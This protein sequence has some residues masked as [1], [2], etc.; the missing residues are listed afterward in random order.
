[1]FW[2]TLHFIDIVLWLL[3]TASTFYVLLFALIFL[4]H[5]RSKQLPQTCEAKRQHRFLVLFPAYGEDQIIVKSVASFLQQ[6]Y[7]ESHYRIMVIS[8]HMTAATNEALKSLPI[9]LL[10]PAFEHSSKAKALQFAIEEAERE[11]AQSESAEARY[12]YVVILD[13]DNIVCDDFLSYLN[14]SCDRGYR[15]IQCHRCAKNADNNIAVLDGLSEEINNSIFRKAHNLVGLSSAL[16]GSGMCIDYQWFASHVGQLSTA[17]EDR[18]LEQLLLL[19]RIFIRY[20][21]HIPVFDEKVGSEDN[22]QRQR[23]RWMSAQLNSLVTML[24]HVGKAL[25]TGNIN[26][27]DK[28]IQQALIPRSM[29]LV[30]TLTM[31]VVMVLFAPWWSMKWW[32]LF[33]ALCLSLLGATP[34][35]LR[36]K[37]L[38]GKLV[39]LPKLTW[40]MLNNL[41]HLDRHNRNFIHTEHNQ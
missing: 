20:E 25:L 24:P 40:K 41:R 14:L 35:S 36:N 23:Q 15:A 8:D 22:F 32:L 31:G 28:T 18:E 1:M 12:D 16:I 9:K 34:A 37:T 7:P 39:L 29:L 17:G 3:A 13:A 10:Q 21:E 2:Q 5:R 27:V 4:F 11:A 30:F 19:D 33:M 26:Y 38:V 6:T